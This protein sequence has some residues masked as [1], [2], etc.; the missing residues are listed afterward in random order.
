MS[1]IDFLILGIVAISMM[2]GYFRGFFPEVVS[3][4]T[5][6]LAA[7]G[8][9]HFSGVVAPHLEGKMGSPVI[10]MWT[11]RAIM[12]VLIMIVGGL[13][14]QL[15]S[16]IVDKAGLSGT[17][18]TLGVAF[19]LI[20]G[21]VVVGV[22]VMFAQLIGFEKDPWWDESKLLPFGETMA[23]GIKSFLPDSVSKFVDAQPGDGS[24][25][26]SPL[27]PES[28]LPLEQLRDAASELGADSN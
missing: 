7:L 17:D 23:A 5:W 15:V 4:A 2:I 14:G 10:E 8:A 6:V 1:Y 16:L 11:S 28:L 25:P 22:L 24:T 19:G 18:K 27:D 26:E 21:A 9:V 20:R 3:V 12:F 13:L